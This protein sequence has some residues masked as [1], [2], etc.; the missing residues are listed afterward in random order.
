VAASL[1]GPLKLTAPTTAEARRFVQAHAPALDDAAR[2]DVV[3]R[4]GR[5]Y[6]ALRTL[7]LLAMLR[8]PRGTDGGAD[9]TLERLVAL[10]DPGNDARL[11]SF[12]TALT[13]LSS[14]EASGFEMDDLLSLTGA[15]KRGPSAIEQAFLDPVPGKSGRYRAFSRRLMRDLQQRLTTDDDV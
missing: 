2:E 3:V 12:L 4:A 10:V 14:P 5:S 13:V 1:D 15:G 11:R 7:S 8:A 9:E 6:E